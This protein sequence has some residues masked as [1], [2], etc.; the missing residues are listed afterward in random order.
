MKIVSVVTGTYNRLPY[1]KRMVM[2]VR[3]SI[4]NG[5]DYEIV[6]VDGGSNDGTI[7]WAEA[8]PDIHFIQ[9][10]KL[11]GAVKAFNEGA[12]AATGKYV[13]LANDD[14]EFEGLSI[15]NAISFMQ[16][17]LDVGVGCFYQDRGGHDPYVD[18]MPAIVDGKQGRAYYGQVCI[19]QKWLGDKVGW[20]GDYLRTYGGDN[21]L[22]ANIL[23]L[24]YKVEPVSCS[25]IHDTVVDDVLREINTKN[26]QDSGKFYKKWTHKNGLVGPVIPDTPAEPP[27][28][29]MDRYLRIFYAPI[30]EPGH[31]LQRRT[32][33]GLRRALLQRGLLYEYDYVSDGIDALVECS[34][35]MDADIILT[36]FQSID[37]ISLSDMNE[38][39][40][41]HPRAKFVNW[42][43]DYHPEILY[44]PIY[45]DVM[46]MYDLVGV[47]TE[48]VKENYDKAGINW[49]YWQI[50][51]EPA[52][53]N[54]AEFTKQHDILFLGNCYSQDRVNLARV[55]Q[56]T[57]A[58]IGLYGFWPS[59][60]HPA[61]DN[62]YDFNSGA[63][64]YKAAKVSI[65]DSQWPHVRGYTSNRLFQALSAG[66]FLLQQDFDGME[67]LIGVKDG[68]HLATWKNLDDLPDKLAYWLDDARTAERKRIAKQGQAYILAEHSFERRV[69]ELFAKLHV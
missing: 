1:V 49:F 27:L 20:W 58:N 28:I 18:T 46:K 3:A 19:V 38:L 41:N 6:L 54:S 30:Y 68:I 21:E 4:G 52:V 26:Q 10:G 69:D 40:V 22:S 63:A 8:Q 35:A 57:G 55:L 36:Q 15:T 34:C 47:V 59:T 31:T 11:L 51:Y 64:L 32:K 37:S 24:G 43:G 14:I 23:E 53:P 16:D 2:S 65:G 50:G 17:H 13:I 9:Q 7:S 48:E 56:S 5:L 66:A 42:N 60:L 29:D 62:L 44:D 67:D 25:S 45:M 61:G 39:R 12:F 33:V